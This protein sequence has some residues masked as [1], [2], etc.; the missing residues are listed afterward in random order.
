[1]K[2]LAISRVNLVRY[3]RNR[4][5]I[6]SVFVLPLMIVLLLGA[7]SGGAA[8]PKLGFV[9]PTPDTFT[10]ELEQSLKAVEGLRVVKVESDDVAVRGVE[11]GDLQ[12]AIILPAGYQQTLRSGMDVGI[13]YVARKS[14]NIQGI[15]GVVNAAVTRQS[16][17]LRT[18]RFAETRGMG[19]FDKA[20]AV[21]EQARTALPSV[22][23]VESTAGEP[24][25]FAGLGQFDMP[26][27]GMLVLFIFMNTLTGAANLVQTRRLG[28]AR[29]M[30]S[31]PTPVHTMIA[32]EAL[33][34][35]TIA[36][37]QGGFIIAGTLLIFGVDWGNPLGAI[38]TI[39]VFAAVASGAAMLLGALVSS[40]QQASGIT[41]AVGLGLAALGGA[42]I[43]L[44]QLKLLSD[45]VYRV[46]HVTPHAWALE[47]FQSLV[48]D[49]GG[50]ADIAGFLLILAGYAAVLLLLATWRLRTVLVR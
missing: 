3:F 13:R 12:A 39:V 28:V 32:G 41:W 8:L 1:M 37:I 26:A 35:F 49:K 22:T 24:L 21:A 9:A 14:P 4:G 25:P 36:L 11:R 42:M 30:Y 33:S 38:L 15:T 23:V 5:S 18:A 34:Q 48:A 43:P 45:T 19:T 29:R 7:A 50:V 2:A 31:T 10:T 17:L 40:D 27:Q 20:L 46:A 16:T 6:F 44:A 47:A